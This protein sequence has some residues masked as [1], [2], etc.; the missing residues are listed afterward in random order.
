MTSCNISDISR[1]KLEWKIEQ[2]SVFIINMIHN[3]FPAIFQQ[4]SNGKLLK[5]K[6]TCKLQNIPPYRMQN[7]LQP[8]TKKAF[9]H[10]KCKFYIPPHIV[11]ETRFI[12][13]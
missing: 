9:P 10:L 6:L 4:T 12:W 2:K 8:A 13:K 1:S 7:I 5:C 3:M 11:I